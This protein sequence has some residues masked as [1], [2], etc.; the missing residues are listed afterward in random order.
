MV[1]N[2]CYRLWGSPDHFNVL[3]ASIREKYPEDKIHI[4]ATKRNIGSHTYDGIEVG[5]ERAAS[6]IEEVLEDFARNGHAFKK[7]SVVGYS[8]GGLVSRYAIGLLYHKGW[9]D[10]LQAVVG[11]RIDL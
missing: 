9:F 8:L 7:I 6:E 2:T 10:K 4:L 5:G 1:A 3:S 11:T